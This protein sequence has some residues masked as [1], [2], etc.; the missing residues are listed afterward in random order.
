MSNLFGKL[1]SPGAA[2]AALVVICALVSGQS[3]PTTI[4]DTLFDADGQ[5]YNGTLTI[6]WSTFNAANGGTYVQQ[7]QTVPIVNGNL[8]V[9]LAPNNLASPPANTYTVLYQSDGDQ[10]YTE[11]WTVPASTTPL[12]VSQVRIG[13]STGGSGVQAGLGGGSSG[14]VTESSVTNL[15]A[16]LNARPIKG[17]GFGTNAVAVVDQNGQIETAVGNSTDCVFVDGTSGPCSTGGAVPIFVDNEVPSGIVNGLNTTFTL[18]SAPSGSSLVLFRNG[19]RQQAG[20]D[21]TLTGSSIVFASAAVPQTQ[22]TLLASY[23]I[24]YGN[25]SSNAQTGPSGAPGANGCGAVSTVTKTGAYQILSSDN[26]NMIIESASANLSLPATAPAAGWCVVL[27]NTTNGRITVANSGNNINGQLSPYALI[28][29]NAA[30]VISDGNGYWISGAA[31][32]AMSTIDRS[33]N[34]ESTGSTARTSF[35]LPSANGCTP[36]AASGIRVQT[37]YCT[38]AAGSQQYGFGHLPIP[39]VAPPVLYLEIKWRTTD[40]NNTHFATFNWFYGSSAASIDPVLS[41]AGSVNT[42]ASSTAN[43]VQTSTIIL[44]NPAVNPGDE[45]YFYVSRRGD[46]DTVNAGVDVLSV[47]IHN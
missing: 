45:F 6:Q 32:S 8:L 3:G 46:T 7:R 34:T 17:P 47:R 40:V 24:A 14:P 18:N 36:T 29:A 23:R 20:V 43:Q 31:G 35:S 30:S 9:Q 5:R 27:L 10:Q 39:S 42:L 19:V 26:G 11:T 12:K 15:V 41:S 38:F 25:G 1:K 4:Q 33:F 37:G 22:D 13:T 16:D 21:Y 2:V 28:P 44:T